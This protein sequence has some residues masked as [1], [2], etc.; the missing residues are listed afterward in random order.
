MV[1]LLLSGLA[2]KHPIQS[3]VFSFHPSRLV[4]DGEI[5]K[6]SHAQANRS[7][8]PVYISQYLEVRC[9]RE[10]PDKDHPHFTLPQQETSVI[11]LHHYDLGIIQPVTLL[12]Y[13]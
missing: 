8:G 11:V 1:S 13:T 10:P 6:L 3:S 5:V 12:E 4:D 9:L 7:K 2:M